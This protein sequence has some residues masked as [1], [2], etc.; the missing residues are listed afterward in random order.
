VTATR[1]ATAAGIV[2]LIAFVFIVLA[3]G[4]YGPGVAVI[5]IAGLIVLIGAGNMLY[6]RNS[7]YARAQDRIRPAQQ[8]HDRAADEANAARR[9]PAT[10]DSDEADPPPPG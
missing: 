7:H 6:G 10:A 1:V 8:T 4:A 2:F 9:A 5:V 3:H